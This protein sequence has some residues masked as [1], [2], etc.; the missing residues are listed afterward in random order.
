VCGQLLH[1]GFTLIELLVVMA[2]A[3]LLIGVVPPLISAAFPGVQLKAAARSTAAGLR[4]AR[5]EA[6]RGGH[7]VAFLLDVEGRRYQ[8]EGGRAVSLPSGLDL[9]LEAAK[10][11]MRDD[12]VGGVRFYPDGS[13]TGGR[14][15]V[16]RNGHGYQVG[17]TWLTGRIAIGA[18]DGD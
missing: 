16:S 9:K 8:V 3:A 11:E 4:L 13:S 15:L 5:E 14:V 1:R 17:V 12:Q 6:I 7:D 2:L 18:W 10:S